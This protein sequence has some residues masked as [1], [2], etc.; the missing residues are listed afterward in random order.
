VSLFSGA[1]AAG[2]WRTSANAAFR[3]RSDRCLCVA[4]LR[5]RESARKPAAIRGPL[6]PRPG[7]AT[8]ADRRA[9]VAARGR[10]PTVGQESAISERARKGRF[11]DFHRDEQAWAL[12]RVRT[13]RTQPYG[14]GQADRR[15][16]CLPR[17]P[18]FR[19][20]P[21]ECASGPRS[22]GAAP[23][24]SRL[25][26]PGSLPAGG[27]RAGERAPHQVLRRD[28]VGSAKERACRRRIRESRRG[29]APHFRQPAR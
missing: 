15:F 26:L 6:L 23:A 5:A 4:R 1:V 22:S 28:F 11:R 17:L 19:A 16:P 9:R 24:C 20:A 8:P 12:W 25:A 10:S 2:V 21:G 18:S 3:Y 29:L 14:P 13:R 7:L 27:A